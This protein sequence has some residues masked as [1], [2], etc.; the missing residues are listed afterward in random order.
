MSDD[1]K[2]FEEECRQQIASQGADQELQDLTQQWISRAAHHNYSY[3]FQWLGR[4]VIQHPQDIV[5]IQQLIWEIQPELI[6]ETGVARGGSL[7][8][9]ASILELV[10]LCGGPQGAKVVGV[11]IDI[12]EHN[13]LAIEEHPMFKRIHLIEGSSV[14]IDTYEKV[15]A[16]IVENQRVLV[17][18][19]SN[20]TH[21]H[22]L[23][24]LNLYAPLTSIGSYCVVFD[25]IVEDMIGVDYSNRP[26]AKGNNPKTAVHAYLDKKKTI[27][28][29]HFEI[30]KSWDDRLL[31]TVAP[32]GFL[33][34]TA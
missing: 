15:R 8:L 26:W 13:R 7:I 12:R 9:S 18:L 29:S 21:D 5:A 6:I 1:S 22:V 4:P 25:T 30:D 11:D 28:E 16:H 19:D 3:H 27:D 31:I 34:R 14:D 20:H 33:R 24:E 32:N 10:A 17:F 2:N 23:D